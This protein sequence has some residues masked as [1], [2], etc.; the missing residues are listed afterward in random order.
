[1]TVQKKRYLIIGCVIVILAAAMGAYLIYQH[2]GFDPSDLPDPPNPSIPKQR[3]VTFLG[4]TYTVYYSSTSE[5]N[6]IT[7]DTWQ[8]K[9]YRFTFD[10]STDRLIQVSRPTIE[11]KKTYTQT[12]REDMRQLAWDAAKQLTSQDLTYYTVLE[13]EIVSTGCGH[14]PH[15]GTTHYYQ[16]T[17]I[18]GSQNRKV[19]TEHSF[20]LRFDISG[21]LLDYL[22]LSARQLGY[23]NMFREPD[24]TMTWLQLSATVPFPPY[25]DEENAGSSEPLTGKELD[26]IAWKFVQSVTFQP[27]DL[28]RIKKSEKSTLPDDWKTHVSTRSFYD[29]R[30]F[31]IGEVEQASQQ[32]QY[33]YFVRILENGTILETRLL[34]EIELANRTT[35]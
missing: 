31:Y 6:G 12:F 14:E 11:H 23:Y 9:D 4:K 2:Y 24:P 8:E 29:Y 10:R 21:A 1:M 3:S 35:D 26:D 34:T 5:S 16:F 13:D 33:S 32:R 22:P 25:F 17:W 28:Y 27:A 30:F 15:I 7:Y 19:M 18:Y 20:A